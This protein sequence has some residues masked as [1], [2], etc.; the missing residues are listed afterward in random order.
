MTYRELYLQ[1]KRELSAAGVDT[2][3]NDAATLLSHFF[4]LDRP[5]L[6]LH[7]G[8]SPPSGEEELFRQAVRER[9]ARRPLQYILGRWEFLGLSLKVGEG[10]LT[11]REDTAVLVEA[12][13]ERL[14]AVPSPRGVDLCAGTGAVALGLCS[15][16][17]HTVVDCIELSPPALSYLKENTA[18]HPAFHVSVRQGDIL[19]PETAAQF[20]SKSLDFIASNPP[21]I[22]SG[23]LPGLQAEVRKE[24]RL[25]LD[26]GTDGLVFYRAI[27]K[28]W[29]PLLKPG[30]ILAVEIGETQARDVCGIFASH[31]LEHLEVFPDWSGLDRAVLAARVVRTGSR[32]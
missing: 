14:K 22:A 19:S 27:A 31:G 21:Y 30:G 25:A 24:P 6:A 20:P 32:T 9:A 15:L 13:A 11:P 23:E 4:K 12:L 2:P 10:V 26:G 8:E 5:G 1:A 17:P 29:S 18:A 16:L 3:E 7:G 28:L